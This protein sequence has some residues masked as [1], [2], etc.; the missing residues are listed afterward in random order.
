MKSDKGAT[1]SDDER[2]RVTKSDEAATTAEGKEKAIRM[3]EDEE[4]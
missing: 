1:K 4:R 3:R 2:Q